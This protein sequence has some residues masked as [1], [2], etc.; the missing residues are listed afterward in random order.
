MQEIRD[1][2]CET[3]DYRKPFKAV[4][5]VLYT[6]KKW[7]WISAVTFLFQTKTQPLE[8]IGT[9]ML[10]C[11]SQIVCQKR[12]FRLGAFFFID[13]WY[14]NR[15]LSIYLGYTVY[16]WNTCILVRVYVYYYIHVTQIYRVI[17]CDENVIR[18]SGIAGFVYRSDPPSR[19][20]IERLNSFRLF[21]FCLLD[22][23]SLTEG[24]K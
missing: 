2:K 9:P 10:V 18:N 19:C 16:T 1:T 5:F 6:R 23:F 3:S 13:I 17:A 14:F 11:P 21:C 8:H 15:V 24:A 20:N 4:C 12:N 7:I 22:I